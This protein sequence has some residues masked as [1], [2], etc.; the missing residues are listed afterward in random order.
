M[1]PFDSVRVLERLSPLDKPVQN[2]RAVAEWVLPTGRL[3]DVLHGVWLG[4]PLH[5]VAVQVPIGAWLSAAVLDLVGGQ[6]RGARTLVGVGLVSALPA[7]ST[8][9]ADWTRLH[10]DQQRVGFVH[11]AANNTALTLYAAS[12][13]A[14]LRGNDARGRRLGFAGLAVVSVGGLLG[15]HLSFAQAAG[16]NHTED[17]PHVVPPGW[18][19]VARLVELA[20]KSPVRRMVDTVPVL[21]VRDGDTVHVLA[22]RCAHLSGP[23]HEGELGARGGDACIECPWH[24]SVF[25]LRD[26]RVLSGPATSPQPVFETRTTGDLVEA[27]LPD[28]R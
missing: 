26:G 11:A 4:H 6:E 1:Q 10:E 23:L 21:V 18:H 19:P 28:A 24:G 17:V 27:R 22:D 13:I 2:M 16:A 15:G 20:D 5:P 7:A 8:G 3:R 9:L 14:R 12:L 25:R